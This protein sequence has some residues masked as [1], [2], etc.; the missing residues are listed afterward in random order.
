MSSRTT[1]KQELNK[2]LVTHVQ[3]HKANKT[4]RCF[5]EQYLLLKM[6]VKLLDQYFM[7]IESKIG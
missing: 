4:L 1:N 2:E 7:Y 6:F 5:S 3:V